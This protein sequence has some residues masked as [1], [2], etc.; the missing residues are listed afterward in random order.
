MFWSKL[1]ALMAY[2]GAPL[3]VLKEYI[4]NQGTKPRNIRKE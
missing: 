4:D 1:Y 2:G 3:S